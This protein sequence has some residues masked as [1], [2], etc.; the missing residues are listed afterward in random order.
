MEKDCMIAHGIFK[1]LKERF[2]ECSDGFS[3]WVCDKC[4]I[5][6]VANPQI[7]RFECRVCDDDVNISR[8]EIPYAMK[9]LMQEL[10]TM[11]LLIR[12]YPE[13]NK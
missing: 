2:H 13:D 6:A 7:S 4:G 8:I 9:L 3:M 5:P 10:L 1:F 12:V 11:G